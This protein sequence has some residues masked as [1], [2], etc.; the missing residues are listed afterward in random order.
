[1]QYLPVHDQ[2]VQRGLSGLIWAPSVSHC[3]ITLLYLAAGAAPLHGIQHRAAWL[4]GA[5]SYSVKHNAATHNSIVSGLERTE[6]D[7]RPPPTRLSRMVSVIVLPCI[8][9]IFIFVHF[10]WCLI[11]TIGTLVC[12]DLFHTDGERGLTSIWSLIPQVAMGGSN[13]QLVAPS[14]ACCLIL[15]PL[16]CRQQATVMNA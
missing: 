6:T 8:V 13:Y 9:T 4:Q 11:C 16:C 12:P 14:T 3:P 2:G 15:S 10:S 1:M 5:P 7:G